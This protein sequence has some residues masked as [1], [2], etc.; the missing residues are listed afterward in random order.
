MDAIEPSQCQE[1]H[2]QR[3]GH[4]QSAAKVPRD[5]MLVST[6]TII[7]EEA[8]THRQTQNRQ[9]EGGDLPGPASSPKSVA[10]E[11]SRSDALQSRCQGRLEV[12]RGSQP[13]ENNLQ[14]IER[15]ALLCLGSRQP[16]LGHDR[17]AWG[18]GATSNGSP[19]LTDLKGE[20]AV[21]PVAIARE[22]P[23]V[24]R[25][26]C[27]RDGRGFEQN[28]VSRCRRRH[29]G[30]MSN[31][32]NPASAVTTSPGLLTGRPRRPLDRS[33]GASRDRH[34][35]D[36]SHDRARSALPTTSSEPEPAAGRLPRPVGPAETL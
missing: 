2:G 36:H 20:T 22:D 29:R 16:N 9:G 34:N 26:D 1:G 21:A 25:V 6:G 7:V 33:G 35:E 30:R 24:H 5:D 31:V 3:G 10:H 15:P 13:A 8:E 32:R 27:W 12:C 19:P 23:P 17:P 14:L 4:Q 28:P 18:R 11:W